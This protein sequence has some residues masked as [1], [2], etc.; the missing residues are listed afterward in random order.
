[1]RR[2][3]SLLTSVLIIIASQLTYAAA[4]DEPKVDTKV[5]NES[6]EELS[7]PQIDKKS[8]QSDK[9]ESPE[10]AK[11]EKK[12]QKDITHCPDPPCK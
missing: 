7:K 11:T 6:S 9:S 10:K 3:I 1:M 4:L 12:E 2:I 8:G 5:S